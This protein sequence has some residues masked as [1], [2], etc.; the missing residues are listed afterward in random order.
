M[1][2]APGVTLATITR[3]TASKDDHWTLVVLI[4]TSATSSSTLASREQAQQVAARLTNAGF[5]PEL[6]EARNPGYKDLPAGTVGYSVRVGMYAAR[7]AARTDMATLSGLGYRAMPQFS[8]E[9]GDP[10]SGPWTIRVLTIDPRVFRGEITA[11]HGAS[12][13]NRATVSA[14]ARQSG[15]LAAVN[16]GFPVMSPSDGVPGEP[17]GLFIDH[18]KVLSETTNGRPSMSM[19]NRNT[20]NGDTSVRF[21]VLTTTMNL[22]IGKNFVHPV[23]GINRKPGVIRNCGGKGDTPTDLPRHDTTCTDADEL[24]V[25]TPEFGAAAPSGDGIEAVVDKGGTVLELR[26]RAGGAVPAC[27][28]LVQGI[29]AEATWLTSN[30]HVGAGLRLEVSVT[31]AKGKAV[32]FDSNDSAVNGGPALVVGG[33]AEI[34]PVADG[35]VHLDDPSFLLRWVVGRNPRTMAGVDARNRILLVTVDG[36]QPGYSLGLSLLEGAQLM[37]GLGAVTAMNLDG[38]GSTAMAINGQLVGSPSDPGG[39]RAVGD[40]IIVK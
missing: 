19:F 32:K 22:V 29:G 18:G 26:S 38:G 7:D 31:D 39:E 23:E 10:T 24:V 25:I 8:G 35:L 16:A 1:T 15:A 11:T 37:I 20:A 33:Q 12:I 2:L 40:A 17:T 30:V 34:R 4:P 36:H 6:R 5:A 21:Q 3:G 27:G 28:M 9:D 13:A 14:L